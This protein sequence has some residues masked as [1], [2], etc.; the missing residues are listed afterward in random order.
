MAALAL[1]IVIAAESGMVKESRVDIRKT[2]IRDLRWGINE[3]RAVIPGRVL[4]MTVRA[5]G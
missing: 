4:V 3:S 1:E 5:P 2:G